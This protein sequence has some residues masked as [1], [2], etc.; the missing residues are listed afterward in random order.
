[1]WGTVSDGD[2]DSPVFI[3]S[4]HAAMHLAGIH[5]DGEPEFPNISAATG[6]TIAGIPVLL[7]KAAGNRLILVDQSAIAVTDEG[8]DVGR[9]EHAAIQMVDDPTNNSATATATNMVSAFQANAVVLRFVRYL[10]WTKLRGDA[11]GFIELYYAG[12]PA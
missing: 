7:S 10:H 8:I 4:S 1:L 5:S 11:A 9:A 2:P 6:G 12:S 3:T